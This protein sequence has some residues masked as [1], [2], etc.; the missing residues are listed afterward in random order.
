MTNP[1]GRVFEKDLLDW[2]RARGFD[3]ERL[4]QAGTLD[5]GD[6]VVK[7]GGVYVIEAKAEQRIDLPGYI[8]EARAERDNYCARRKLDPAGVMPLV[9]VKARRKPISEAYVVVPLE[10]FFG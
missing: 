1:K 8:R 10:E 9:V 3:A 2:F 6:L 4:R 7:D 5:E